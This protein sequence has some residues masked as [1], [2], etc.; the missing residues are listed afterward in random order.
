MDIRSVQVKFVSLYS[1]NS[2]TMTIRLVS[3]NKKQFH[4]RQAT[5]SDITELK[6]LYRNTIRSVN[7]KDYSAEEERRINYTLQI[8]KSV[9]EV[10]GKLSKKKQEEYRLC[11][12]KIVFCKV[13]E[14]HRKFVILHFLIIRY[15]YGNF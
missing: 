6:E 4:I 2:K 10:I 9:S 14:C 8:I 7:R 12:L 5:V 11:K 13:L 3:D 1:N 15:I